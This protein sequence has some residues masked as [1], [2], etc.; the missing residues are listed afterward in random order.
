[1]DT[2]I[3]GKDVDSWCTRCK[4]I[5]A[6]TIEAVVNGRITRVHCNTCRGQH[7]YR[8]VPPGEGA[9]AAPAGSRAARPRATRKAPRISR[10]DELLRGRERSAA[11]PYAISERFAESE[12]IQHPAFGLGL[13]TAVKEA[14]KIEVLFADGSRTLAHHR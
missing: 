9:S 3:V 5:L 2:P 4:L 1:M 10:Y 14:N 8:P 13:V 7:A 11:R 12:L 6:H